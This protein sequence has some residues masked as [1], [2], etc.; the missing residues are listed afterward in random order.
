VKTCTE[1]ALNL[2]QNTYTM[3]KLLFWNEWGG[4][5]RILYYFLLLIFTFFAF[6]YL[7]CYYWGYDFH[8]DWKTSTT[9]EHTKH[10]LGEVQKGIFNIPIEGEMFLL[11]EQFSSTDMQIPSWVY[12]IY[13][14]VWV[15]SLALLLSLLTTLR[16]V[17]YSAGMTVFIFYLAYLNLDYLQVLNF[18]QNALLLVVLA[19]FVA[20]SYYFQSF[21]RQKHLLLPFITFSILLSACLLWIGY[22]AHV[23][24]PFIHLIHFGAFLPLAL[25]A[26]FITITAQEILAGAFKLI[27]KY[28]VEGAGYNGLHFTFF[29]LIYL[30]H[31]VMIMLEERNYIDLDLFYL[32]IYWLFFISAFLGIWGFRSRSV[33]LQR[34]FNMEI[35]IPF[36]YLTLGIVAMSTISFYYLTA[37]DSMAEAIKDFALYSYIAVGIA[38]LIYVLINF[39]PMMQ[40]NIPILGILYEGKFMGYMHLRYVS[41]FLFFIIAYFLKNSVYFQAVSGFNNGIGDIYWM[42]GNYPIAEIRYQE[43]RM[44]DYINHRSNY[45]LARL[46]R[47][48]DKEN[49]DK[50]IEY[51]KNARQRHPAPHT[52]VQLAQFY[53]A[54]E[55][56]TRAMD[57]LTLGVTKFPRNPYIQ[58]NL[59][60]LYQNKNM[61]DSVFKYFKAAE[62]YADNP[63]PSNNFWAYLTHQLPENSGDKIPV[64]QIQGLNIIGRAN[65][66]A[67]FTKFF[68]PLQ[69]PLADYKQLIPQANDNTF[70]Y[71][72]NYA[73]NRLGQTDTLVTAQLHWLDKKDSLRL[74]DAKNQF[75][76]A[77]YYYYAG[78]V[79]KGIDY[80]SSM[81]KIA[82]NAYYNVIL[83]LWLLEQKAYTPAISYFEKATSLDNT[84]ATYYKAI[85]L[86]EVGDLEQA[87]PIWLEIYQKEDKKS[88]AR[89]SAER[90]LKVLKD[91]IQLDT[92]EDKYA[93]IH[94]KK[95][96]LPD[97]LLLQ[98][99]NHI[100]DWNFKTRAAADLIHFYLDKNDLHQAEKIYQTLE[101][102]KVSQFAK[103]EINEA[104]IRLLADKGDYQTLLKEIDNLQLLG[105]HRPQRAFYRAIALEKSGDIKN[106]ERY[107]LQAALA[108]P[109]DEKIILESA[110]YFNQRKKNTQ[111][112]YDILVQGVRKNRFSL[113]LQKS[114]ALQTLEV[115]LPFYGQD[116]LE[117]IKNLTD[118]EDY[119]KFQA[120]FEL[121]KKQIA[122]ARGIVME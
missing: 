46:S 56:S 97:A 91:S 107:Y 116:A 73:L 115:G 76:E 81:P 49:T 87:I 13:G 114:Y 112:A 94:Y 98:V 106:A 102:S 10:T 8:F 33:V 103:S 16:T 14:G 101:A 48:V 39:A 19:F 7:V 43:A 4:F 6:S 23:K 63:T 105:I 12:S 20:F 109:F 57:V 110:R 58:N 51:L 50:P 45:M 34:F 15:L 108:A 60:L 26:I 11:Q 79:D 64:Q 32:D 28:N 113:A 44:N 17:W 99:Y 80:M 53:L 95:H 118:A 18:Y 119:A 29:S 120:L 36:L 89:K 72:Y 122:K 25:T 1:S 61:P 27:V 84:L 22:A 104:Y 67:L 2:W 65:Q 54:Q 47:L 40:E 69:Q 82:E 30:T 96:I 92:D 9:L 93:S 77:C 24:Y 121:R 52:I 111:K 21:R 100:K 42:E 62:K 55:D 41:I 74:Y 78:E 66:L 117:E 85:A 86:T 90:I 3:K 37:N 71:T 31:L 83:G 88:E 38:F 68:K 70:A 5:Y 59:A 35:Q 75:I